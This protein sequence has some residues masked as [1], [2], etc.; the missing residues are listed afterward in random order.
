[1]KLRLNPIVKKDLQ[2]AAR[3]MRISWGLFAYEAL[4]AMAFLLAISLIQ[5]IHGYLGAGNIYSSLIYLFPVLAVTQIGIVSLVMPILTASSI[6]GERE[7]QTLDLML[8]TCMSPF[9]IVVGKVI[10]A[11]IR[12]LFFVVGSLPIMALSFVVGGLGWSKLFYFVL[13]VILQSVLSG[14]IGIFCS[15]V[16]RRS[17]SAVLLSF[18]FYFII[19][20]LTAVPL[21][22]L[23]IFGVDFVGEALLPLLVNPFLFFE[24]FFALLMTG[25]SLFGG[26]GFTFAID[27]VGIITR[28]LTYEQV[29]VY[30]S[31]ASIL[32]LSLVFMLLAAWK[33][34]PLNAPGVRRTKKAG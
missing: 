22:I 34:N 18:V 10:S 3:S 32:L 8:T 29:W 14:S 15:A 13:A 11:V 33:V 9:S 30:A 28:L 5:S 21:L 20:C 19:Y 1:M 31:A 4:L 12:I 2:V 26:S 23:A 25:T 7:R 27:D 17:I 16:C 6:S 24:E